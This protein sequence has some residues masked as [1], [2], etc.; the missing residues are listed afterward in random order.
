MAEVTVL[1]CV[2]K[3]NLEYLKLAIQSILNQ[4]YQNFELLIVDDGND[5]AVHSF[6]D[7][8]NDSRI[9]VLKNYKNQGLIKSLNNGLNVITTK[10]IARMDADDIC[11]L[12]RLE[13]QIKFID[14][15]EFDLVFGKIRMI[16]EAGE[17]IGVWNEDI[18]NVISEKIH[19]RLYVKNCLAHPTMLG[20]TSILKQLKYSDYAIFAEDYDLWL[21]V[22]LNNYKIGKVKDTVLNYRIH[23]SSVTFKTKNMFD[24]FKEAN[25]KFKLLVHSRDKLSYK[26][27]KLAFF[28]LCD[29]LKSTFVL[30][31]RFIKG[32]LS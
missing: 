15:E 17:P 14:Q 8:F 24:M 11:N 10:Y 32:I 13:K 20:K 23:Q 31:K 25:L 9:R 2:Y 22:I 1:L 18:A 3:P 5:E 7:T 16:N 28:T 4:T 29:Y 21:R 12:D 26:Y 30:F 27:I 19:K 6:Y